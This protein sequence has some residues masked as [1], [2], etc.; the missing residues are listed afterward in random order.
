MKSQAPRKSSSRP[1]TSLKLDLN[2]KVKGHIL[3][4]KER[5]QTQRGNQQKIVEAEVPSAERLKR[6]R[7][8]SETGTCIAVE[9]LLPT[10]LLNVSVPKD[11]LET[12]TGWNICLYVLKFN[13]LTH[14][15]VFCI[16]FYDPISR[17]Q[18]SQIIFKEEQAPKEA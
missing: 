18:S 11:S 14:I 2:Q 12:Q 15:L 6:E 3:N 17:N 5:E 9:P 1:P 8:T 16:Y 4:R 7:R 10:P 13:V